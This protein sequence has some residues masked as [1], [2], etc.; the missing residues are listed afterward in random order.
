MSESKLK[1]LDENMEQLSC[2]IDHIDSTIKWGIV[3]NLLDVSKNK[4]KWTDTERNHPME[5]AWQLQKVTEDNC[6]VEFVR[7]AAMELYLANYFKEL[8]EIGAI[9]VSPDLWDKLS[10]CAYKGS[11]KIVDAIVS[12]IIS[13]DHEILENEHKSHLPF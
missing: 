6:E 11:T 5:F 13:A 4:E 3:G 12:S 7:K 1:S 8:I 9:T 10:A 2:C